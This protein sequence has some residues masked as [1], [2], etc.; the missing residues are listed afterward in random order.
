MEFA[1]VVQRIELLRPKEEMQVQ[2]LPM[3]PQSDFR[4][5]Y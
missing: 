3:A 2:F 5:K 4:R 1:V